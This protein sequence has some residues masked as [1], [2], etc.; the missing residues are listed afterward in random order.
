MIV[1]NAFNFVNFASSASIRYCGSCLL[2][3]ILTFLPLAMRAQATVDSA[4][5]ATKQTTHIHLAFDSISSNFIVPTAIPL[6]YFAG[7]C[8]GTAWTHIDYDDHQWGKLRVGVEMLLPDSLWRGIGCFRLRV[9]VDSSLC[10][11]ILILRIRHQSS[12]SEVYW[13]GVLRHR[14]GKVHA[15]ADSEEVYGVLGDAMPI[16]CDSA[17][18]HLLAIRFSAHERHE[19]LPKGFRL[20]FQNSSWAQYVIDYN[21]VSLLQDGSVL[22][23]CAV[24]AVL[25]LL[26]ILMFFAYRK[27]YV[28]LWIAGLW[29]IL[30]LSQTLEG[31]ARYNTANNLLAAAYESAGLI[32]LVASYEFSLFVL[33]RICYGKLPMFVIPIAGLFLAHFVHRL[34][35]VSMRIVAWEW[36]LLPIVLV[37]TVEVLRVVWK[38]GKRIPYIRI[39]A[40]GF[41]GSFGG[42]IISAFFYDYLFV[43]FNSYTPGRLLVQ[44]TILA[45]PTSF[46]LYAAR[47]FTRRERLL[48]RQNEELEAEV[49]RRT[50]ELSQANVH[51]QLVN[52]ELQEV[53]EELLT[54]NQALDDANHF[55]TQMLSIVAHDLKNPLNVIMNCVDMLAESAPKGS[56]EENMLTNVHSSADRMVRLIH[57]LLDTAAIEIGKM[58]IDPQPFNWGLQVA[59]VGDS[60][61]EAAAQKRQ[62]LDLSGI[63][64][65]VINGDEERLWQ[66]VDNLCSNAV[67][68]SALGGTIVIRCNLHGNIVR[69]SVQDSGP[70]LTDDD[71]TKLFGHFQRLSAQPTAGETSSGVGLS[72]VKKVVELHKGKIWVESEYG[73]GATFF[74]E[75]PVQ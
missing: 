69:L 31:L 57:D 26:H 45:Y 24:A 27:N 19:S 6:T 66:V 75:L 40:F 62:T 44:F 61:R 18:E 74:V 3:A 73:K 42:Y 60:Y 58:S 12:A 8:P 14:F 35:P 5:Q 72:I 50:L 70:G 43:L 13:D 68:Y 21:Q 71:K 17:R 47:E 67:K 63:E 7:D 32:L 16:Y 23:T 55:K 51:I 39:L 59:A 46:T 2:I 38:T 36:S 52:T 49:K 25:S 64:L 30:F 20:R 29:G 41:V 33:Y 9:T 10:N 53:N 34:L 54:T 15:V 37:I 28:H 4:A 1:S 56:L 48:A 22:V 11:T 65:C